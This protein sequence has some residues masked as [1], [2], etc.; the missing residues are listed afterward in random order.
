MFGTP[1]HVLFNS[2]YLIGAYTYFLGKHLVFAITI[3]LIPEFWRKQKF[4]EK[5]WKWYEQ[6]K[7]DAFQIFF[8][9][10]QD[11]IF[12]SRILPS[13]APTI[14]PTIILDILCLRNQNAILFH[15]K[16]RK[17][18]EKY[19]TNNKSTLGKTWQYFYIC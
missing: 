11:L 17:K 15:K 18:V 14:H 3:K 16:C 2:T 12:N 9:F 5:I 8:L 6:V 10:I 19:W 4:P 1:L 13:Q 7:P